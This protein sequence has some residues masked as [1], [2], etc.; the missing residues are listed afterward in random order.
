M[1]TVTVDV[2]EAVFGFEAVIV[3]VPGT[4]VAWTGKVADVAPAGIETLAGTVA[5]AGFED[6]RL[7][8]NGRRPPGKLIPTVSVPLALAVMVNDVG[9]KESP[10]TV[11]VAVPGTALA[12]LAVM[13]AVPAFAPPV[14]GNVTELKP[15]GTVTLEGTVATFGSEETRVM[16][17]PDVEKLIVAV[18]VP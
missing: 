5:D 6:A 18:I 7:T 9:V 13:V 16:T 17:N 8:V 12:L 14:T 3:V 2:A 1:V 15:L 4:P 10:A 11:A